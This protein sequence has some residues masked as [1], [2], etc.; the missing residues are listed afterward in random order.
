MLRPTS[1]M[2]WMYVK[3]TILLIPDLNKIHIMYVY[4]S[5][6]E[7]LA[8]IYFDCRH[9]SSWGHIFCKRFSDPERP[10]LNWLH[11]TESSYLRCSTA[12]LIGVNVPKYYIPK[13][14]TSYVC[15]NIRI[16]LA[17]WWWRLNYVSNC[18]NMTWLWILLHLLDLEQPTTKNQPN[19][20]IY[21]ILV[22]FGSTSSF[23]YTVA[24]CCNLIHNGSSLV[25]VLTARDGL[26]EMNSST[27]TTQNNIINYDDDDDE[28]THCSW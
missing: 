15:H 8:A 7:K 22:G 11:L 10:D 3:S 1:Y 13:R 18:Y 23:I 26:L 20:L 19:N 6:Q 24:R 14:Y 9:L 17:Q 4:H 12:T 27:H 21:I 2:S 5:S 16:T 25:F 28:M